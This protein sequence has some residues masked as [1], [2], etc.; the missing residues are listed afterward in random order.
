[1]GL[2]PPFRIVQQCRVLEPARVGLCSQAGL[3][4]W[5]VELPLCLQFYF[6]FNIFF[7]NIGRD[8]FIPL[9][10]RVLSFSNRI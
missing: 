4:G 1:M 7:T 6:I 2:A 9:A 5:L 3:V 8:L 10:G